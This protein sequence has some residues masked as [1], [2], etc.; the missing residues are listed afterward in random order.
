[1]FHNKIGRIWRGVNVERKRVFSKEMLHEM[2][3]KMK[4][5][6]KEVVG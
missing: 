6:N 1:M 5:T 2:T 3:E 4:N